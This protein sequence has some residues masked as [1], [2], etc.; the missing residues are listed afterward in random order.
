MDFP[1]P[2]YVLTYDSSMNLVQIC[3]PSSQVSLDYAYDQCDV[4]LDQPCETGSKNGP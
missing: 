3:G 2:C 1:N 4:L